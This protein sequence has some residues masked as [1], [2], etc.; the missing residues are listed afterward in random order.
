MK[1]ELL[2]G[3]FINIHTHFYIL[4]ITIGSKWKIQRFSPYPSFNFSTC[5]KVFQTKSPEAIYIEKIKT[6]HKNPSKN[7]SSFQVIESIFVSMRGHFWKP[8]SPADCTQSCLTLKVHRKG[9][10]P[11]HPH[12]F[13]PFSLADGERDSSL[14]P[15]LSLEIRE[16]SRF[17]F[18]S[19]F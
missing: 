1:S 11:Q 14:S 3:L 10:G 15:T 18:R 17:P 6:D 7:E 12:N 19:E 5:M 4:E 13:L 8:F 9:R 2:F 16:L